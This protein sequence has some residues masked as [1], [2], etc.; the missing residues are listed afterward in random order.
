MDAVPV[1]ENRAA[2]LKMIR[3]D[4]SGKLLKELMIK[5]QAL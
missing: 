5:T 3:I 2:N 4:S 1:M